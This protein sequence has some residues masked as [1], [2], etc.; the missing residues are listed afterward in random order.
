MIFLKG[1]AKRLT[2]G[3][4]NLNQNKPTFVGIAFSSQNTID[5]EIKTSFK[6]IDSHRQSRTEGFSFDKYHTMDE[7]YAWLN[8]DVKLGYQIVL[9]RS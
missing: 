8:G 1:R 7:I 9:T 6:K 3:I 5:E 2:L 4:Q